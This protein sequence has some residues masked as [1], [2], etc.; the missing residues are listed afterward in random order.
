MVVLLSLLTA[1]AALKSAI[2]VVGTGL[3]LVPLLI[4]GLAYYRYDTLDPE[5]KPIDQYPLYKEYDFVIIGGGS[6]GVSKLK[7]FSDKF[8]IAPKRGC[9]L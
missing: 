9:Y 7:R 6:A 2:S 5:N 1:T 8:A 4:A 3:W